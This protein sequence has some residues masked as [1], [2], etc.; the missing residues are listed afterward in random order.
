MLVRK[1]ACLCESQKKTLKIESQQNKVSIK[2]Y[3]KFHKPKHTVQ[4]T[5][6]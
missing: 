4:K 3:I 5:K 2:I 6:A 1:H